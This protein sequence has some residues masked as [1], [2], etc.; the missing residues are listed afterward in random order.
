MKFVFGWLMIICLLGLVTV[1]I[2]QDG[3]KVDLEEQKIETMQMFHGVKK[4]VAAVAAAGIKAALSVGMSLLDSISKY[5]F[6]NEAMVCYWNK[7]QDRDARAHI[8]K[9][10]NNCRFSHAKRTWGWVNGRWYCVMKQLAC[11][12]LGHR[13]DY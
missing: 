8:E 13:L 12:T 7:W 1:T 2:A 4:R 5:Y 6:A 3:D 11:K 10:Y 9:A